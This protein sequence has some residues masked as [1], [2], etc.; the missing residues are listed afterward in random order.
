MWDEKK[1]FEDFVKESDKV[2]ADEAFV[3]ELKELEHGKIKRFPYVKYAAS[4]AAA[5]ACVGIGIFAFHSGQAGIQGNPSAIEEN[6]G[7]MAGADTE[8]I[9]SGSIGVGKKDTGT[10]VNEELKK[11]STVVTDSEGNEL[12]GE[13]RAELIQLLEEA[14]FVEDEIE[15]EYRQYDCEGDKAFEIRIIEDVDGVKASVRYR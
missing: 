9:E 6:V 7:I 5:A 2:K 13:Q 3:Q 14:V 10:Q 1:F 11:R 8:K 15:G 12:S 4:V